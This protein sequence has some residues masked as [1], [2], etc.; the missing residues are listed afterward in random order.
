M[1]MTA[2]VTVVIELLLRKANFMA[3]THSSENQK[4]NYVARTI[5][6]NLGIERYLAKLQ[7][8]YNRP[9]DLATI[10]ARLAYVS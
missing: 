8:H 10:L 9:L 6:S 4:A 7:Y 1:N 5:P 2:L 3:L